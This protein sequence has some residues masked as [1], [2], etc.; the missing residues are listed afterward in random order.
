M[1]RRLSSI[2]K[3]VHPDKQCLLD[4]FTAI[5]HLSNGGRCPLPSL[6][7][8]NSGSFLELRRLGPNSLSLCRSDGE[9]TVATVFSAEVLHSPSSP[10]NKCPFDWEAVSSFAAQTQ[11]LILL[12]IACNRSF[13]NITG[14]APRLSTH[15]GP[16]DTPAIIRDYLS[17]ASPYTATR[18]P[19]RPP[20]CTQTCTHAHTQLFSTLQTQTAPAVKGYPKKKKSPLLT[21]VHSLPGSRLSCQAVAERVSSPKT[22]CQHIHHNST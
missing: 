3:S 6:A 19:A 17:T 10:K 14:P 21:T 7:R 9:Q 2:T 18:P 16:V 8:S 20:A 1:K 22:V 11:V 5:N 13:L 4:S 12:K 15:A